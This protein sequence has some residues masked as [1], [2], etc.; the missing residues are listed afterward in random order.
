MRLSLIAALFNN[1]VP[2]LQ[3]FPSHFSTNFAEYARAI[4]SF[5]SGISIVSVGETSYVTIPVR[6]VASVRAGDRVGHGIFGDLQSICQFSGYFNEM[7]IKNI[8]RTRS[9]VK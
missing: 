4:L 6:D 7:L 3:T 2:V 9:C 1:F 8:N 5:I